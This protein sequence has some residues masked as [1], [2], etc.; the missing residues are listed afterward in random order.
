MRVE[1]CVYLIEQLAKTLLK[2][3]YTDNGDEGVLGEASIRITIF[4]AFYP[5][6]GILS[7]EIIEVFIYY[8]SPF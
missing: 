1:M 8:F 4:S 6:I 2:L 3:Q 5:Y 7:R